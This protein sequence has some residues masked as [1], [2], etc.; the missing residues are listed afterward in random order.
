MRNK[1]IFLLFVV[2]IIFIFLNCDKRMK[3]IDVSIKRESTF[4]KKERPIKIAVAAM[5][6]PK[7]TFAIY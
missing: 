6:S 7:Q 1:F 4:E 2:L 5:I 3:T